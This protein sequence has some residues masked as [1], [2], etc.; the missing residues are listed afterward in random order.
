MLKNIAIYAI[1]LTAALQVVHGQ[2]T[3]VTFDSGSFQIF[4]SNTS[5]SIPLTGGSAADG[6]GAVFQLGYFTGA[7]NGSNNFTGT[8]VPLTGQGS[9]NTAP[10]AGSTGETMNQTSIG[11]LTSFGAGN[12]TF[13]MTLLFNT[14]DSTSNNNLPPAGTIMSIR[15]FD[16]TSL[17]NSNFSNIV[18]ND[19]WVWNAPGTPPSVVAM[20]LDDANLEWYSI[21]LGQA[22]NTAFHTTLVLIPEPSTMALLMV[23]LVGSAV[24][25]RRRAKVA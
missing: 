16:G 24:W 21:F 19:A 10:I 1:G 9:A 4:N 15:F 23:G 17:G 2:S 12:G 22:G 6:N 3:Q 11:D 18:S 7:V 5:A 25:M 13:A 8:F 14:L 20:T